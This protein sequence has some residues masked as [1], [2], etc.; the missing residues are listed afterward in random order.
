MRIKVIAGGERLKNSKKLLFSF[1][2][3]NFCYSAAGSLQSKIGQRFR[4]NGK[5][6]SFRSFARL[7]DSPLYPEA[8]AVSG[9]V[10]QQVAKSLIYDGSR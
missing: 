8:R 5:T 10:N 7:K 2:E 1:I 4:M 9:L 3:W 6:R